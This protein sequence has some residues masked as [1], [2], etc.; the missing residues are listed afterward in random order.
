[1]LKN[2]QD[3]LNKHR[4]AV[5]Q[6]GIGKDVSSDIGV[7]RDSSVDIKNADAACNIVSHIFRHID[8]CLKEDKSKIK[9]SMFT[10]SFIKGMLTNNVK[11][12]IDDFIRNMNN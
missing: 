10:R 6:G 7:Q 12:G 4:I 2:L 5:S 1:M 3:S 8:I 9:L 11:T